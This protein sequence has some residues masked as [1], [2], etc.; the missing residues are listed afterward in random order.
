MDG[1]RSN[2]TGFVADIRRS[3]GKFE[4]LDVEMFSPEGVPLVWDPDDKDR[5]HHLV[6]AASV[7]GFIGLS[8]CNTFRGV[9][10]AQ[11]GW[12]VRYTNSQN[13]TVTVPV[14]AWQVLNS[15]EL[16]PITQEPR[17]DDQSLYYREKLGRTSTY[18]IFHHSREG[19]HRYNPSADL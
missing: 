6:P 18:T 15:G 4:E 10:P 12:Y 8:D 5:R 13:E 9:I 2:N 11:H 3:N 17:D 1:V 14:E 19:K 16:V 7:D